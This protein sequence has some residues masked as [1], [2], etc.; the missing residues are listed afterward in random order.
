MCRYQCCLNGKGSVMFKK[1]L[2][3]GA[4]VLAG[5]FLVKKTHV[6]SYIGTAWSQ[7]REDARVCYADS[8]DY[9]EVVSQC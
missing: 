3:L 9:R 2:I 6:C 8:R 1:V 4:V 5:L 7:L